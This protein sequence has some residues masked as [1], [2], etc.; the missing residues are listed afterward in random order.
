[1]TQGEHVD[2][3]NKTFFCSFLHIIHHMDTGNIP[4]MPPSKYVC[5]FVSARHLYVFRW[6]FALL[7]PDEKGGNG[8]ISFRM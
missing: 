8:S 2:N 7:S 4:G 5:V 1:M 6:L 3:G